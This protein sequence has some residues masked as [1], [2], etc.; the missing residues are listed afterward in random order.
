MRGYARGAGVTLVMIGAA[1]LAGWMDLIEPTGDLL[2]LVTGVLLA[3]AGF[4]WRNTG[5]VRAAVVVLGSLYLLVGMLVPFAVLLDDLPIGL[6]K[7]GEDVAHVVFGLLSVFA[8]ILLPDE[9][10]PPASGPSAKAPRGA[11]P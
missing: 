1:G 7:N 9:A 3:F 5:A 10:G 6:Y 4:G 11:T 8:A 2:H